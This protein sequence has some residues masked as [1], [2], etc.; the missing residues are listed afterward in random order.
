M[1]PLRLVTIAMCCTMPL[2]TSAASTE[3][4]V[5]S[6]GSKQSSKDVVVV[7]LH[8]DTFDGSIEG[9]SAPVRNSR[10]IENI[11]T[12]ISNGI[13]LSPYQ[14]YQIRVPKVAENPRVSVYQALVYVRSD[15][16][17]ATSQVLFAPEGNEGA[18][19]VVVTRLRDDGPKDAASILS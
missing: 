5:D 14:G 19:A 9:G 8:D 15:G 10:K 11:E 6:E 12:I 18:A 1:N 3:Y 4:R 7:Q 16:T 17:P 2:L 13:Y